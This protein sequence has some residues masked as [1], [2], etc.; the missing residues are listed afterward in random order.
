MSLVYWWDKDT[1]TAEKSYI[2]HN[3]LWAERMQGNQLS[4]LTIDTIDVM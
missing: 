4:L 1:D 3:I 2:S